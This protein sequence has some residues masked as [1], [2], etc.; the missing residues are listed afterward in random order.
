M[1]KGQVKAL[2]SEETALNQHFGDL[3]GAD[4]ACL[5]AFT[6]GLLDA[7][8]CILVLNWNQRGTA[9]FHIGTTPACKFP[10]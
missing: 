3:R 1:E 5:P 6:T 2:R 7:F 8:W 4:L 10:R 9:L